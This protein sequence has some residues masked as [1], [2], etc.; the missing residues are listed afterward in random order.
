VTGDTR[1]ARWN[2]IDAAGLPP[3]DPREDAAQTVIDLL[4]GDD[5]AEIGYRESAAI[6]LRDPAVAAAKLCLDPGQLTG[7]PFA[8]TENEV[9]IAP[10]E[11]TELI[12]T[13]AARLNPGPV[14]EHVAQEERVARR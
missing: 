2:R 10:W 8:F 7:H 4:L 5:G 1:E 9:L 11:V 3:D 6:R 12:V 13:T 14:L